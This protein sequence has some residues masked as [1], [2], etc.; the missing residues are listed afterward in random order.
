MKF[1]FDTLVVINGTKV[2]YKVY[3]HSNGSYYAE[4]GNP[5]FD[6]FLLHKAH[7][8]WTTRLVR[9]QGTAEQIGQAIES[10]K[11]IE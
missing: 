4:S 1:L 6:N 3:L 9:N 8:E 2:F 11:P 10:Q 7:N 5:D